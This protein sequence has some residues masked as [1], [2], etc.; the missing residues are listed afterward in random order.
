[1]N[2][3]IVN[4]IKYLTD[5][6]KSSIESLVKRDPILTDLKSLEDIEGV[7]VELGYYGIDVFYGTKNLKSAVVI[8]RRM[9]QLGYKRSS[10]YGD[11][12]ESDDGRT[13]TWIFEDS[14]YLK[15]NLLEGILGPKCE[16]V[17]VGMTEPKPIMEV[18]CGD[19]LKEAK[20]ALE[21]A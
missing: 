11:M 19:K 2:K 18:R 12:R 3:E 17:Q 21:P 1:M 8:L 20:T 7:K 13:R 4:E 6:L 14:I 5:N 9:K 10:E 16:L 15:V